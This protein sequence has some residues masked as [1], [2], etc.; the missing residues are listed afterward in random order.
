MSSDDR[1]IDETPP[2]ISSRR[3]RTDR[4]TSSGDASS[5]PI[6]PA[7]RSAGRNNPRRRNA[8]SIP[9]SG[10]E[11][12]LWLQHGGWPFLV[13]A[14]VLVVIFVALMIFSQPPSSNQADTQQAT[15]APLSLQ[16]AQPTVAAATG[17][18][19]SSQ[20]IVPTPPITPTTALDVRF[21]VTGTGTEGLFLRP[22][23]SV[24]GAPIKTL[25]EG[26][27]VTIIGEDQ[28][29]PDR[30]WKHIRDDAGSEGWASAEF[31][32]AVGP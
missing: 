28:V 23:P 25:P 16:T 4:L 32:K 12:I 5:E 11:F 15:R 20:S 26:S 24:D 27:E 18:G 6:N 14:F 29:M 9:A 17:A 2:E 7:W 1:D 8:R 31:L 21:R 30:V 10:Q 19:G 13:A 3:Q 22:Q